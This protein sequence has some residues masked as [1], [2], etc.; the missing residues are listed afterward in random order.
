MN[1]F[2]TVLSAIG[3]LLLTG[4]STS[5]NF[6]VLIPDHDGKV[7]EIRVENDAGKQILTT[8][9]AVAGVKDKNTL[10]QHQRS[11]TRSDLRDSFQEAINSMPALSV[12]Y[13]VYFKF[14]IAKLT[15]SSRR[16]L[17][18]NADN[19]LKAVKEYHPCDIRVVGHTDTAGSH[20]LNAKLGLA[21]ARAVAK[22]LIALGISPELIDT[23]S[24][25]EMNLR[26]PTP[27]NT[28]EA[29]NRRVEIIIH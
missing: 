26:K 7:G 25:S 23:D 28:V 10:P 5:K 15:K 1:R 13:I 18:Q 2:W 21:R 9:G 24:H 22:K 29:Q 4:C 16:Y 12:R 20:A 27:D 3:L 8:Q 17:S 6:F 14:G 19:I 11:M